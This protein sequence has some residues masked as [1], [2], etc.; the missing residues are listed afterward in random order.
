MPVPSG[1]LFP[2]QFA[3]KL[4]L[5]YISEGMPPLL[6]CQSYSWPL[7]S[8]GKLH[9]GALITDTQFEHA[10]FNYLSFYT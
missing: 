3:V 5:G 8:N 1:P 9:T 6:P 7:Q 4:R 10:Y 2:M